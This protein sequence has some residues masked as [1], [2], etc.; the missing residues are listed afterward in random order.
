MLFNLEIPLSR[1]SLKI[2]TYFLSSG[3]DFGGDLKWMLVMILKVVHY[4]SKIVKF[5]IFVLYYWSA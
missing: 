2:Q 3:F 4:F 5:L 1:G